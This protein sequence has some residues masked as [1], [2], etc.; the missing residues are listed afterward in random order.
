M[1]SL[2]RRAHGGTHQE[3]NVVD[4]VDH[5]SWIRGSRRD[6]ACAHGVESSYQT[7][8]HRGRGNGNIVLAKDELDL[9]SKCRQAPNRGRVS[10]EIGFWTI[11]PDRGGIVSVSRKEQAVGAIKQRDGVGSVARRRDYFERAPSEI[12]VI[13]V[14]HVRGDL[15]GTGHICLRIESGGGGD[16]PGT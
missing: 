10:F 4:L 15:P 7:R 8:K 12:N 3:R 11:Q 1:P 6:F 2:L 14:V 5:R 9:W 16:L 13:A